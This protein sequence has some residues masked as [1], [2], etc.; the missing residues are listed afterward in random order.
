MPSTERVLALLGLFQSRPVWTAA[1]LALRLGVTD[2]TVRRDVDRL[3]ELGYAI[4]SDR[5][6]G[7][8]Y[9]LAR[10][11][12]T[13][14]LL[15]TDEE[16]VA[17]A[18]ALRMA[19]GAGLSGVEE[20]ALRALV[21]LEH[22]L[23]AGARARVERLGAALRAEAP[24][25]RSGLSVD[26]DLLATLAD[27]AAQQVQARLDYVDRKGVAT[28]RRVEPHR[29]VAWRRRWYLSAWDLDRDGWRSFRLD[30]VAAARA[31]TFRF[32]PRP[33]EPDLLAT[34]GSHHD[35]SAYRHRVELLV[36]TPAAELQRYAEW[37]VL[38]EVDAGTTRMVSGA[39]DPTAAALW[40]MRMPEPVT[41]VGD[42]AVLA[43]VGALAERA[44]GLLG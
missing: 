28:E 22:I 26:L 6:H 14:P 16:A 31:S 10:G 27:C 1:E 2:R 12:V 17:V 36:A 37:V 23:P 38:E 24:D 44:R 30:R 5:G 11:Q 13:P 19:G 15:L 43:A 8:G 18:L 21:K 35:A 42:D 9:R 41:V 33:G 29:L 34:L 32:R 25:P 20:P 4:G 3:R 40:L 39:D 7:G